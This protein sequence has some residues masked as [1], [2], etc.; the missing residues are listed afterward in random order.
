MRPSRPVPA[1]VNA[2]VCVRVGTSAHPTKDALISLIVALPVLMHGWRTI[3]ATMTRYRRITAG[4]T[5]F[6]TIVTYRRRPILCND[7]VRA[8]LRQAIH[9]VRVKRPFSLDA[10]VL[11]PDHLHCIWTLP[12]GDSDYSTRWSQIK[13]LVSLACPDQHDGTPLLS[14]LARA[15]R[16]AGVWQR[17]FWEHRIRDEADL[18]RHVDY[19]HYNPVRHGHAA[20]AGDWPFSTFWRYAREGIYSADWGGVPELGDIGE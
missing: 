12:D 4:S 18:E 19:I 13:A 1:A 17:R 5:F 3:P 8:A 16:E 6:F 14:R 9:D 15:R 20:H 7:A 10:L 11:L 2:S